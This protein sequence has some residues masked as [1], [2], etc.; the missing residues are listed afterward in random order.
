M[1]RERI[2]LSPRSRFALPVFAVRISMPHPVPGGLPACFAAPA[3]EASRK[4]STRL[5]RTDFV[6]VPQ[7]G[8]GREVRSPLGLDSASR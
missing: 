1:S 8:Q 3:G 6:K 5:G 7:E 4:D 2:A